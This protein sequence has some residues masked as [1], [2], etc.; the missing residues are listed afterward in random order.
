MVWWARKELVCTGP[1]NTQKQICA[2]SSSANSEGCTPEAIT[3]FS[4]VTRAT[5][6]MEIRS[7]S[8][9]AEN[10]VAAK[11]AYCLLTRETVGST[12]IL[13]LWSLELLHKMRRWIPHPRP[14]SDSYRLM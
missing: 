8:V 7:P 4:V 6:W 1:V 13:K 12:H 14:T 10:D 9:F 11:I 2:D 3:A 5:T